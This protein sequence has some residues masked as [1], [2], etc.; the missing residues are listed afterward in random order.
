MTDLVKTAR[1]Y[2]AMNAAE[3]GADVLIAELAAEVERLRKINDINSAT[4]RHQMKM[5]ADLLVAAEQS[6]VQVDQ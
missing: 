5:N 3:S 1:E 6:D 2:L 4:I